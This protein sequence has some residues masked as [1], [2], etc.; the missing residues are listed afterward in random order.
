[1]TGLGCSR[2]AR[3][4]SGN[5]I[6]FLLLRLLRCFSSAAY[7]YPGYRFT[8][9]LRGI[10]HAGLPH[11]GIS[12]SS[13]ASGFPKLFVACYALH[14]L[15]V[16][17]HPPCALSNLTTT[18]QSSNFLGI[19]SVARKNSHFPFIHQLTLTHEERPSTK[20]SFLLLP[21]RN[22]CPSAH[23]PQ[24]KLSSSICSFQGIQLHQTL[25]THLKSVSG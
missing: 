12:G 2:F 18:I 21:L 14:R 11:S 17:R 1:M 9:K 19:D 20:F 24:Q 15:Q 7:L 8:R 16:P 5:R 10:T 25:K 22:I 3:H 6:R 13:P 4:Y 23:A